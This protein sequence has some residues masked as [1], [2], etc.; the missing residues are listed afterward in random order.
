MP[1]TLLSSLGERGGCA[2]CRR[3]H[4]CPRLGGAGAGLT[5]R[6][7]HRPRPP[8]PKDSPAGVTPRGPVSVRVRAGLSPVAGTLVPGLK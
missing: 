8:G 4:G 5:N 1:L 3:P 2:P 6:P 7:W